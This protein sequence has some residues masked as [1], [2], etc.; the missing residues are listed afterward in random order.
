VRDDLA[1]YERESVRPFGVNPASAE[2]HRGYAERLRLP[3]PLLSDP[4][5][6]VA[7]AYGAVRPDGLTIARSVVLIEQDGT[8]L[9][10]QAGAPGAEIV[11][12]ALR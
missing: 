10:S 8:I 1:I 7:R 12:E 9:Y 2:S 4:D 11:L 3:F 6:A 5:L